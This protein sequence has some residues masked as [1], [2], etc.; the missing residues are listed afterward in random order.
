MKILLLEDNIKLNST[1]QKRLKMKGYSVD[2]FDDGKN[3]Y[4]AIENNYYCRIK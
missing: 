3:A 1:I 4:D 2:S